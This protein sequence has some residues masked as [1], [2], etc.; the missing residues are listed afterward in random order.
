MP[1]GWRRLRL[2]SRCNLAAMFSKIEDEDE[3][4]DEDD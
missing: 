1:L 4:E 2:I 3:F